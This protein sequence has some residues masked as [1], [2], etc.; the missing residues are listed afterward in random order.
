MDCTVFMEQDGARMA[1]PDTELAS[2]LECPLLPL[3]DAKEE[4][5]GTR[6]TQL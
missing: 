6:S 2:D 1:F 4:I 3:D 5:L